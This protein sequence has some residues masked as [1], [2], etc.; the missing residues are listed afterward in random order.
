MYLILFLLTFCLPWLPS[1]AFGQPSIKVSYGSLGL[2]QVV[3]PLGV[4]SGIFKKNN[5]DAQ[6][7]YIAGRSVLALTSGEVKFGFMGGPPAILA[8]LGGTDI[9]ILAGLNKLDQI[10]VS[11]PS[12][13]KA[14]DL[15][16]KRGG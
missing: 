9:V 12:V 8:R 7:V 14:E 5:V 11:V 16:G 2:S 1:N 10:L 15:I 3:L 6:A 13:N 4:H